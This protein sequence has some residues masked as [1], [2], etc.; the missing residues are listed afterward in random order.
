MTDFLNKEQVEKLLEEACSPQYSEPCDLCGQMEC[1][2]SCQDK[3]VRRLL[4]DDKRYDKQ[5]IYG[6]PVCDVVVRNPLNGVLALIQMGSFDELYL[7]HDM[8]QGTHIRVGMNP[9]GHFS[10]HQIDSGED[11]LPFGDFE[12]S[13]YG[14]LCFLE[15]FKEFRPKAVILVTDNASARVKMSKALEAMG[16]TF[17]EGRYVR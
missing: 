6:I 5:D 1:D 12:Y 14:V 4:I 17:K 8:G 3:L 16:Y 10:I 9:G 13:G 11:H 2:G 7:D 15:E